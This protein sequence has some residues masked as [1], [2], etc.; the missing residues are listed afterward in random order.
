MIEHDYKVHM[1]SLRNQKHGNAFNVITEGG[2]NLQP[3]HIPLLEKFVEDMKAKLAAPP[4]EDDFDD[5]C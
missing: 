4:E 2:G 3:W 5:L 1:V